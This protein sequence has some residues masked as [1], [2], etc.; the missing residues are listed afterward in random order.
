[1]TIRSG[2]SIPRI[3]STVSRTRAVGGVSSDDPHV[4]CRGSVDPSGHHSRGTLVPGNT[5][6]ALPIARASRRTSRSG[7]SGSTMSARSSWRCS[8]RTPARAGAPRGVPRRDSGPAASLERGD[9]LPPRHPRLADHAMSTWTCSW[10]SCLGVDPSTFAEA[11]GNRT[12][13]GASAPTPV[14]KTGGSTRHP[15]ASAAR[16]PGAERSA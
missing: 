2:M 15:N 9:L 16:I 7:S 1:M 12:R 5:G 3:D 13:L 11:D 14:L 4:P 6:D 8:T 10:L